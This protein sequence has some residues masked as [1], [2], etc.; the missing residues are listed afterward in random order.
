MIIR[1]I[2]HGTRFTNDFLV[3]IIG[4]VFVMERSAVHALTF[5]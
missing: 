3:N 2:A 4:S 1:P 5:M